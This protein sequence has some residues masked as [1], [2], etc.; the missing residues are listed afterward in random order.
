MTK[1][2]IKM[3]WDEASRRL[4]HPSLEEISAMYRNKKV[5]AL[6]KIALKYR[7]FSITGFVMA[8]VSVVWGVQFALLP[9]MKGGITV[10]TLMMIYFTTCGIIDNWLY[11][12]ISQI[13]C[14]EM[15][16]KMVMEKALYY[17]KKHLQSMIFTIPFM[18]VILATMADFFRADKYVLI[19]MLLGFIIGLTVGLYQFRQFMTQYRVMTA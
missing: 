7:Q 18:F 8:V 14:Y 1:E 17:K 3:S 16:V 19:G 15:T 4:Y 2:E 10:A 11:R 5:T 13:D 12:G 9:S 6:N